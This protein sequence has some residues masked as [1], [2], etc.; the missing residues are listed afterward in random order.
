[1]I[2]NSQAIKFLEEQLLK[3][4]T[5]TLEYDRKRKQVKAIACRITAIQKMKTED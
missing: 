2:L 1:M 5:I 4:R 3:S